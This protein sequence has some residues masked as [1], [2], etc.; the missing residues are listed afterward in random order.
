M[1]KTGPEIAIVGGGLAGTL[2]AVALRKH[3]P[4]AE[5]LLIEQGGVLGGNHRWSFF[6]SDL[7]AEGHELLEGLERNH[8]QRNEVRFPK[9]ERILDTPYNSLSSHDFD[10]WARTIIPPAWLRLETQVEAVEPNAI[11]LAGGDRR[12]AGLVIDARGPGKVNGMEVG[13]QKFVGIELLLPGH[14][15]EQP[16]IMDATV[17]QI[18]GYRFVY[19]LPL[20]SN[21]LFIEDTY[22]S[23]TPEIDATTLLQRALDYA[24]RFGAVEEELSSE[25]GSLPIVIAGEP[26]KVWP[27][28]DKVA[29]IGMAGGMFHHTTGYSLPW[30]VEGA[31]D[32][33]KAYAAGDAPQVEWFR[34][35]FLANWQSQSYFRL[36]NTLLFRA[37]EPNKRYCT[38]EHFYRL[39]QALIERFYSGR[40]TV[41]D[42]ARVLTGKPPV[43]LSGALKAVMG[44]KG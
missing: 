34:N 6:D 38:F 5:V 28:S 15:V 25:T 42:K 37:A 21:R 9:R 7:A 32:F 24:R 20:D 41:G 26:E 40:L 43:P 16:I 8:W 33:A 35:R 18:D 23:D 29:R 17:E 30:A 12:E 4:W 1:T 27:A 31:L 19:V 10:R 14:G 22:Y 13:W 2:L 44:R 36:L 11:T 3:V 39:P